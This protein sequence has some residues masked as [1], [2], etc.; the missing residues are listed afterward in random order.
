MARYQ[1][2]GETVLVFPTLGLTVAPGDVFEADDLTGFPLVSITK[3][4]VTVEPSFSAPEATVEAVAEA[5][6][7]DSA[8]DTSEAVEAASVDS[9]TN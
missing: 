5:P 8:P 7:T 6:V 2:N 1:Y 3:A 9:T 4:K